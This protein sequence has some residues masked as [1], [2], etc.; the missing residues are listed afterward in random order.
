MIKAA[1]HQNNRYYSMWS[2]HITSLVPLLLIEYGPELWMILLNITPPL[3]KV[4]VPSL[5]T[6]PLIQPLDFPLNYL[7]HEVSMSSESQNALFEFI[8]YQ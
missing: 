6:F 5:I 1:Q 8:S 7:F 3:Y 2:I 4:N